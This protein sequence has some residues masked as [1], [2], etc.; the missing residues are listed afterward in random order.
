M[1][2]NHIQLYRPRTEIHDSHLIHVVPDEDI[3]RA[4]LPDPVFARLLGLEQRLP[5]SP[6]CGMEVVDP[7]TTT[8]PAPAFVLALSAG[9]FHEDVEFGSFLINREIVD[10]LEMGVNDHHHLHRDNEPK[11]N[12]KGKQSAYLTT[13]LRDIVGHFNRIRELFFLPDEVLVVRRI[14]D[15]QPNHIDRHVFLVKSPLDA[16]YVVGADVVP[17]ALVVRE[18]PVRRERGCAGQAGILLEDV[19]WRRPGN[20]EHVHDARL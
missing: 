3:L 18:R 4:L 12:A 14:L 9:R 16:A 7:R 8:R 19:L 11:V 6:A 10:T 15:I 5:P 20:D 17:P 1:A 13:I 2:D